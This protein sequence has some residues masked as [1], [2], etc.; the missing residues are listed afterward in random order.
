MIEQGHPAPLR[1]R[2]LPRASLCAAANS[3]NG[4]RRRAAHFVALALMA[5]LAGCRH[6]PVLSPFPIAAI[7]PVELESAPV[8]DNPPE[9]ASEQLPNLGPVSA[10]QP[11]PPARRR[12]AAA[13]REAEQASPQIANNDAAAALAIGALSLGGDGAT[14]P[15]Q[16]TQ[17]LINAVLKRIA[18]VSSQ[19]ASAQK[20]EIGQA[21]NYLDQAQKALKTGDGEGAHTLATKASLLM[22]E[23]EKK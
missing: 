8:D 6:K 15:A 18:A 23:V 13:A 19:I 12:P 2:I 9:I 3:H 22:D 5:A 17:D 21:R 1:G 14:H 16:Q 11:S 20:K 7:A 10:P 4:M